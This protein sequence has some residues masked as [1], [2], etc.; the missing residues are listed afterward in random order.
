VSKQ[1]LKRVR[2]SIGLERN[3]EPLPSWA[4]PGGYPIL[5]V[6]SDGET[7]CPKCANR[8]IV[9]I[10]DS[11]SSQSSDGWRMVGFDINYEDLNCYC[12]HCNERIQSAYAE[13]S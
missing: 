7:L 11:I 6:L 5:Y 8:E 9:R 12:C 13:E 1:A 10:D 2:S 3:R 4:W